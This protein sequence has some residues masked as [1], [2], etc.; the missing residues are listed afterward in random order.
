MCTVLRQSLVALAL[1]VGVASTGAQRKPDKPPPLEPIAPLDVAH[2]LDTY[3][4]GQFDDAVNSVAKVGDMIGRNLRRHWMVDAPLWIDAGPADRPHRLLVAASLALET[5]IIRVERGQWGNSTTPPCGGTCV[6]DWAQAQLVARGTP[7]DAERAWYLAAAALGGGVRDWNY[8]Y[9][10]APP[11]PPG[12]A[13]TWIG[14]SGSDAVGPGYGPPEIPLPGLM[15]RA[16]ERFPNDPHIHLEHAMAAAGRFNVTTEGGRYS[17][18]MGMI[19]INGRAAS[20]GDQSRATQRQQAAGLL[21]SLKDDPVVGAEASVRLGYLQWA[22]GQDDVATA[23]LVRAAAGAKDP[24]I[25]YLAR[26]LL[27]WTALVGGDVNAAVPH[28][29][30]AL[31]ARPGSQSA[32]VTLATI[33]LQRGDA[34]AAYATAQTSLDTRASDDDPWRLFLYAHYARLP[35]LVADLRKQVRP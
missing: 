5:E 6:L 30:A 10:P 14:G 29:R 16:L 25:E 15:D 33:E 19:V 13:A 4:A 31:D 20:L 7:D 1:T 35:A 18:D 12:R 32:A 28:L 26:F 3:A 34:A 11:K 22:L 24:D 23:S 2:L 21:N 8:L 27:G 9:R 17:P